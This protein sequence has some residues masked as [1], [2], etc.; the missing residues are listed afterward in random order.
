WSA[1]AAH[2]PGRTANGVKNHWHTYLK[3]RLEPEQT[4]SVSTSQSAHNSDLSFEKDMREPSG[5]PVIHHGYVSSESPATNSVT[6]SDSIP[7]LVPSSPGTLFSTTET[8]LTDA[9]VSCSE[10]DASSTRMRMLSPGRFWTEPFMADTT[11]D[12]MAC[13]G[14]Y[15]MSPLY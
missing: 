13:P 9:P 14:S 7:P 10:S 3:N 8:G 4:S 1:I 15:S 11:F 2:L 6:G 5:E 12:D